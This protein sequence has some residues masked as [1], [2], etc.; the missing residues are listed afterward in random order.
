MLGLFRNNQFTTAF[1]LAL[2][3]GLTHLASLVG[4][5][6]PQEGIIVKSGVLY[7]SWFGWADGHPFYSAAGAAILVFVQALL[8]NH[9]ADEFRILNERSW[10]P[11]LF[12]AL[13]AACLPDFLYLSPPL[14]AATF[15]PLVLKRIFKTYKQPNA[16]ALIFDTA[17]WTMVAT[18]FYPPAIFLLIAG[19]AG[20]MVM[21]AFKLREQLVMSSG[22]F[23][24]LF[25]AWLWYF[26]TDRGGEFWVVQ[27]GDL[28]QKYRFES[29]FNTRILLESIMMGI[30]F[31]IVLLSYGTYSFRKLNQIQKSVSVLY[32]FL[33]AA[34]LTVLVQSDPPPVHLLLLMPSMGIFLSM[35]F[36]AFKNKLVAELLHLVLLGYIL[37]LHFALPYII[38]AG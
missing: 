27:F 22:I 13:V 3:V 26:W 7:Q 29:T 16:T 12:Y 23:V 33:F 8:V 1:S 5:V 21:R 38:A 28:I 9:L 19:Y 37:F 25:L 24:P 4:F 15:I 34:G 35:T 18:L 36:S 2:Y 31:L 14:V 32:W 20:I 10:L 11:G 30:M 17:F 6:Q